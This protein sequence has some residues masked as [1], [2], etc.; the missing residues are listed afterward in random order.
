MQVE[1]EMDENLEADKYATN[2]PQGGNCTQAHNN[3]PET[4]QKDYIWNYV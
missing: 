2:N 3:P 4:V 1:E